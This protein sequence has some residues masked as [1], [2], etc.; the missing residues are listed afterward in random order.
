M[1][2]VKLD[3]IL[4]PNIIT[5]EA[6]STPIDPSKAPNI[7]IIPSLLSRPNDIIN[8]PMLGSPLPKITGK[9]MKK[10]NIIEQNPTSLLDNLS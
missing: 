6:S 7:I 9:V 5:N 1:N 10:E 4:I 3:S 8:M 2:D